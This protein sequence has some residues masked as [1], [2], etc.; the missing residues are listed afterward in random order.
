MKTNPIGL[1]KRTFLLELSKL[2]E[3]SGDV[4]RKSEL[5]RQYQ[6]A[7]AQ[8][9]KLAQAN[10]ERRERKRQTHVFP[11]PSPPLTRLI[12]VPMIRRLVSTETVIFKCL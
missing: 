12:R 1:T 2:A 9:T 3:M 4:Q 8:T 7:L 5:L 6:E 10:Q 11:S